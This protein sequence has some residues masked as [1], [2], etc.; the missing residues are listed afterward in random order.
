MKKK[1]I[2]HFGMQRTGTT[3]IQA[4]LNKN[5][6]ILR[7]HGIC[8]PKLFGLNDHVKIPW[9]LKNNKILPGDLV[10]EILKNDENIINTFVLSAEDF[11]L[12][13]N[14]NFLNILKEIFDLHVVVYLKEQS[15]WLESWYNQHIKW[16]WDKKFSTATPQFF[17]DN[18]DDFYWI[19]YLSFLNN[20]QGKIGSE[21]LH[22]KA[23]APGYVNDTVKDLIE[24]LG[25]NVEALHSY[26]HTNESLSA[27]QLE[28]LR[29]V[30]LFDSSGRERANILEALK[31][32]DIEGDIYGKAVFTQK[33]IESIID[34]YR[35]SNKKL[36]DEFFDSNQVFDISS[37]RDITPIVIS[38]DKV[39]KEYIPALC[40]VLASR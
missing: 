22:V 29:R 36:F 15:S 25:L 32:I 33:Q 9:W 12:L 40:K 23:V 1:L 20:I 30:D 5:K 7:S 16:P 4:V 17:V 28:V 2:V 11:C 34:R 21:R 8:Y 19:D 39:F 31:S 18:I 13:K 14:Y 10:K 37:S 38:D 24:E 6:G 35:V 27:G 3:T 26:K